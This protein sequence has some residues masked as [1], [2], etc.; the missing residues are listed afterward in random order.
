MLSPANFG[1]LQVQPDLNWR[2]GLGNRSGIVFPA[3]DL[4]EALE[5]IAVVNVLLETGFI[6][7]GRELGVA[8][9][10]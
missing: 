10:L 7:Q 5:R 3:N 8:E 4:F 1:C 2:S 6:D 9:H